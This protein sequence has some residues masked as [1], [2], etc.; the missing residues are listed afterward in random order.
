M[1]SYKMWIGG[2][3]LNAVSGDTYTTLNPATEEAIGTVPMGDK[4]DV[5]IAV[6]A[7]R[8]A[9]QVWAHKSLE[10]RSMILNKI[11]ALIQRRLQEFID[12]DILGHGTPFHMANMLSNVIAHTF[13]GAA[14]LGK[15]VLSTGQINP[16]SRQF[17]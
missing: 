9:F 14:E 12:I 10:E 16:A 4:R 2:K 15:T 5:D 11:N 8:K 3:W 1:K 7:A 13:E 17:G 6:E